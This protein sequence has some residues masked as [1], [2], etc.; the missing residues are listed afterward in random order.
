MRGYFKVFIHVFYDCLLLVKG[1][2]REPH[3]VFVSETGEVG[4]SLWIPLYSGS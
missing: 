3:L 4:G 1:K 2:V